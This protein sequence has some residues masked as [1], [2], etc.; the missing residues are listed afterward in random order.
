MN[1]SKKVFFI[2]NKFSGTGYLPEVEGRIITRC[3]ELNMECTIEFTKKRGHAKDLATDAVSKKFDF[4]FAVGGD[5]TVNEVAQG[6]VNT[7]VTMGILPKG[8]GNGLARHL[9]IPLKIKPALDLLQS[10][11]RVAMDTMIINGDLSVNVSGIGFDAHI[12]KLFGEHGKRGL[13]TYAKLTLREFSTFSEFPSEVILDGNKIRRDVFMLSIA[14]SSQFGNDARISPMASVHDGLMD[15]CFLK[16]VPVLSLAGFAHKMFR[17]KVHESQFMEIVR[18]KQVEMHF[19][20]P[21][22]YHIDGEPMNPATDFSI[23]INPGSLNMLVPENPRR[24]L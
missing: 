11:A 17:S 13:S 10:K 12:A 18:A 3:G 21:M 5:G 22:A 2:I 23:Q 7:G 16:K 9:S 4:V 6:L 24:H 15:I 20:Q 19:S 14:N 1:E 8:S